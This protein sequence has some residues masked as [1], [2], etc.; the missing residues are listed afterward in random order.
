VDVAV[1]GVPDGDGK[2]PLLAIGEAKWNDTMGIAHI[3]RLRHI[4]DRIA[5]SGRYDTRGTR[6]LCFS[7]AAFNDKARAAADSTGDVQLVGLDQL[8]GI[9]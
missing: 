2:P 5:Q 6:L 9:P 3:E 4:R 8:Y 1:V 7:G